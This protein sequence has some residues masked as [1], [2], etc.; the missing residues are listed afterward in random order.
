[1]ISMACPSCCS[2][3]LST[4]SSRLLSPADFGEHLWISFGLPRPI[5]VGGVK[6][7]LVSICSADVSLA[8]ALSLL[9][10]LSLNEIPF[11]HLLPCP[12]KVGTFGRLVHPF[13]DC[14]PPDVIEGFV[15]YYYLIF[16]LFCLLFSRN[17][18]GNCLLTPHFSLLGVFIISWSYPPFPMLKE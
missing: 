5:G 9:S 2:V 15:W 12:L 18:Y 13:P 10:R 14:S 11:L 4:C 8:G 1:M 16:L 3:I 7:K 6:S 17:V